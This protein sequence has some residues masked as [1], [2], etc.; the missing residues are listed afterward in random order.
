MPTFVDEFRLQQTSTSSQSMFKTS[1]SK[2]DNND[3]DDDFKGD[4]YNDH[5]S[6]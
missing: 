4:K 6:S 5:L 2:N 3:D 1:Y